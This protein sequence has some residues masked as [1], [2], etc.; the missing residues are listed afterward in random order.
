MTY[1]NRGG[2]SPRYGVSGDLASLATL[3]C[4]IL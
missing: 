1:V 3:S 4:E 2:G